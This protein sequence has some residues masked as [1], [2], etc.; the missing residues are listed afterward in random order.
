MLFAVVQL[1]RTGLKLDIT[2]FRRL[3]R[4]N[5]C[6]GGALTQKRK[7]L[8]ENGVITKGILRIVTLTN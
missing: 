8:K 3:E 5:A 4:H 1:E 7:K 6:K 2:S